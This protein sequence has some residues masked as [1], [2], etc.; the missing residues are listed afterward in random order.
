M[1]ENYKEFK[2]FAWGLGVS[3]FITFC[4]FLTYVFTVNV[5]KNLFPV[6]IPIINQ[7]NLIFLFALL[8]FSFFQ[9]FVYFVV[10]LE[11]IPSN[12]RKK[13]P[14]KFISVIFLLL[15]L[16]FPFLVSFFYLK[17]VYPTFEHFFA[18]GEP[19]WIV[20]L[21]FFLINHII[22]FIGSLILQIKDIKQKIISDI[23]EFPLYFFISIFACVPLIILYFLSKIVPF[24]CPLCINFETGAINWLS[25]ICIFFIYFIF[26]ICLSLLSP[27]INYNL[28]LLFKLMQ[29]FSFCFGRK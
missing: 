18:T 22:F 2:S 24:F 26:S 11:K 13:M 3:L 19:N 8:V 23:F 16:I 15:S 10:S 5:L 1:G 17:N 29:I 9:Y 4:V 6:F 28:N 20:Y 27:W 12:N 25:I 14:I 7:E 21:I